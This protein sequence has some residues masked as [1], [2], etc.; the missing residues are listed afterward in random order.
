MRIIQLMKKLVLLVLLALFSI[1]TLN[2]LTIEEVTKTGTP[3]GYE[4]YIVVLSDGS[5]WS[6]EDTP[7]LR[8]EKGSNFDALRFAVRLKSQVE[9]MPLVGQLAQM[10]FDW[11]SHKP[12]APDSVQATRLSK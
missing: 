6:V 9:I 11:G 7:Q 12:A 2:A 4:Y 10:K 5:R 1:A 3:G 8:G